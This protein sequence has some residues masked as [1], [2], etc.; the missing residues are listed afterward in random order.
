MEMHTIEKLQSDQTFVSSDDDAPVEYQLEE[1]FEDGRMGN[2]EE[3]SLLYPLDK[4]PPVAVTIILAIQQVVMCIT[5]TMSLPLILSGLLC[6]EDNYELL[7]ELQSTAIFVSGLVSVLQCTI[8]IRLPIIQGGSHSFVAPMIAMLSL[9]RFRCPETPEA[10]LMANTTLGNLSSA[11][12]AMSDVQWQDRLNVVQGSLM[13]ASIVQIFLGCTGAIGFLL[14]YIGP[15]TIA[16]TITMIGLSLFSVVYKYSQAH[17]GMWALSCAIVFISGVYLRKIQVPFVWW[18]RKEK[19]RKVS[20]YLFVLLPVVF[21]IVITW[22]ACWILTATGSL[23]DDPKAVQYKARTDAGL[24]GIRN[25]KWFFFPYPG[26]YGTPVINAGGVFGMIAGTLASVVESVGDYYAAAKLCQV[27]APPAHAV[28]RGMLV[29]GLGSVLS[30]SLG[31][32]HGTTSY[33]NNV[34]VI[35]ITKVASRRVYQVAGIMMVCMGV[36]GKVGAALAAIPLPIQGGVLTIGLSFVVSVGISNVTYIDIRSARNMSILGF[37][38]MC[39]F[40]VPE[41]AKQNTDAIKTGV[42][43]LD[44]VITVFLTTPMFLSGA[45]GFFL[46]NTIPGTK[47]ERGIGKWHEEVFANAQN[48]EGYDDPKTKEYE[49]YSIPYITPY[50]EKIT[51]CSNIPFMPSFDSE[52]I[53]CRN[54]CKCRRSKMVV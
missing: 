3:V 53:K 6:Q 1:K 45:L 36:I 33:S 48:P 5:G 42:D 47:A 40:V 19:C 22:L 37:S 11:R 38:L 21:S 51:C 44:A 32:G 17:W 39:G 43:G 34:G 29:E 2:S 25:A 54:K 8:G 26:Q 10:T 14:Q 12:D 31:M 28:N 13:V 24:V 16:P 49:V 18:S 30:G 4:C 15:L 46:D 52:R 35:G 50:L 7:A 41:W 27:P 20:C 9:E 23:P